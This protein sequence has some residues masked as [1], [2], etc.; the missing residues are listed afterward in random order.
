MISVF[1]LFKIGV[2]PS[3]SH[4][5]GPMKAAFAF[6]SGLVDRGSLGRVAA[7]E[8]TLMGSLAFTGRGHATDKAVILG[9]SGVEPEAIDPDE[10]E[11]LVSRSSRQRAPAAR[12]ALRDRLRSGAGDRLR[13]PHA[14]AAPSQH[15]AADRKRRG[16]RD[17][18]GRDLA[19]DRRRLRR[20]RRGGAGLACGRGARPLSLPLGRRASGAGRRIRA[21]DRRAHARQRNGP[22]A[23]GRGR[24]PCGPRARDDV[25]LPR[26]RAHA[27][28]TASGRPQGD[29]TRQG[30]P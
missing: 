1:E 23:G 4:T 2:G 25:R 29:A 27:I 17:A 22:A 24:D 3:S 5:M 16:R 11:A 7:V 8:V 12:G 6:A 28:G 14:A 20:S 18:R 19:L 13:H 15:P 21:H 30:D 10:A 9:L 26:A